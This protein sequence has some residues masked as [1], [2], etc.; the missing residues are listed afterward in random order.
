M[1]LTKTLYE[2]LKDIL[3]LSVLYTGVIFDILVVALVV[4]ACNHKFYW[5]YDCK[6]FCTH[7]SL[8]KTLLWIIYL[9][10]ANLLARCKNAKLFI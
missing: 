8:V 6:N 1:I 2:L 4:N 3:G 7:T 10:L 5:N 9:E